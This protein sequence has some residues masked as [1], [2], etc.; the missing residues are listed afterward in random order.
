MGIFLVCHILPSNRSSDMRNASNF[1]C[2]QLWTHVGQL[3]PWPPKYHY[4][5]NFLDTRAQKSYGVNLSRSPFYELCVL[6][7]I[8]CSD[9]PFHRPIN[10]PFLTVSRV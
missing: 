6:D 2:V 1:V 5:F 10:L 8:P 9:Y 7:T 4:S 3:H